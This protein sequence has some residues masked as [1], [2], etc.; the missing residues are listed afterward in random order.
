[1]IEDA[2][3]R[4]ELAKQ[5]RLWLLAIVCATAGAVTIDRTGSLT[6][7]I[8]VFLCCVVPLGAVLFAYERRRG[9]SR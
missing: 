9:R 4:R 2:K 1:M 8:A 3:T 5:G 7:G 6:T